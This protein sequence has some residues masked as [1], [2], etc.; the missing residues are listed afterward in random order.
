MS[1]TDGKPEV[2]QTAG[3]SGAQDPLPERGLREK[4]YFENLVESAMEGIVIADKDGCILRANTEFQRIFGFSHEELVGGKLDDLIVPPAKMKEAVT[5][6]QWVLKGEK[7]TIETVRRH[8]DGRNIPVSIIASPIFLG[9]NLEAVFGIYRDISE[10]KSMLEELKNSEKRFQDIALSSADW[11]WEVDKDGFYT[12]ASGKVKQ[13]L[14]YESEEIIGKSPFDLM[15]KHEA[16]RVRQLYAQLV[17]DKQPLVDLVNWNLS[18]TGRLVCLQTNAVPILDGDNELIGYRGMDKDITE[19]R[20]AETQILRQNM[21]L[22]AINRLLKKAISDESDS[23]LAAFCLELAEGLTD[24]KFGFIGEVNSRDRLDIIS[25][26][27]PGWDACRIPK[28]NA[29]LLLKNMK[30]RGLWAEPLKDGKAHL[31]NDP[32]AHPASTGTPSGHP[33][34]ASLLAVP[35]KRAD[36]PIGVLALANKES[37]YD[38]DDQKAIEALATAFIEA[39]DRKRAEE[40]IKGE[41]SKLTAII[42]GIEEGVLY[43]D[44][45]D[46]IVEVND[47]F[48]RVFKKEKDQLIGRTLWDVHMGEILTT[49]KAD[50]ETFRTTVDSPPLEVQ[51]TIGDKEVIFRVKP[52]HIQG[53]YSGLILNLVDVSELVRVRREALAASKA[54]SDFLANISHEIRTP[55]NGILG[56]TELA[57]DTEL[58]PEQREYLR[59][60]RS[61]AESLMTLI[62]DILDFSKIEARKLEIEKTPFN[63]EDLIFETLGPLA[64]QAHRNKLD[65]VCA[66]P[67]LLDADIIGDPGRLR[68]ILINLV[69]NA[70]KFTE[71]GEVVISVE[72]ETK[73]GNNLLLHFVIADTGIGIPEDKQK[74]IFDVF[75][76]ADSSMTRKYGGTG[77]GLAISSQLVDLLGGRIWV[78]STVGKGSRFHFTARFLLPEKADKPPVHHPKMMFAERPALLIED[79]GS[80]RGFI[81]QWATFWGLRVKEAE[82]ADE[83]IVILDE[84]QERKKPFPIIL[85]DA[86]LP[87]HDSFLIL[88]YIKDNPELAKSVIMMMNSSGNRVDASPWLKVGISTHLGKPIKP[89][90]LKKGVLNVLGM[91]PQPLARAEEAAKK[92]GTLPSHRAYR[93]LIAEDN[94]VNQR[95][96]IY[97][98]EKQGHQV[99]GA[100][101]GEEALSALERENFELILMDVQMPKMDGFQATRLIRAKE[102]ETGGHIPIIAMTAHAMKGDRERCL[103]IGM[104]DYISKPLNVKQLSE[105]IARVMCQVPEEEGGAGLERPAY[106]RDM[107]RLNAL[108]RKDR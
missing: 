93:I 82:S 57:L 91:A 33:N 99:M 92:A 17:T 98:L 11:I 79:N 89:A 70:V 5:L 75:A 86:N 97:M 2:G 3:P 74:I 69:G 4:A 35:L 7:V 32:D 31:I 63:L 8:K 40:A 72:E 83:A 84:A 23:E 58:T 76:Q 50:I 25:L 20:N 44:T 19:R 73:Q 41:T 55:M 51:R 12:F 60:I 71:K 14:G 107:E 104:D 94:L 77:L 49:L 87:G 100:M 37:G 67:P 29:P 102:R 52:T 80:V 18:K 24:S 36:R 101:N 68:Q 106:N 15:P 61:S 96:A 95:V 47:Y 62:N 45:A 22:E 43:A 34:I 81:R 66:I 16:A 30:V 38:R 28:S 27:I 85:L 9:E 26:S 6:T 105:T 78:E 65:L 48:L 90:E 13:I 46:R 64:I 10:Q 21:L 56:M 39:L 108:A 1:P 53:A 103:E 88:D 54:K 59:G 42:S